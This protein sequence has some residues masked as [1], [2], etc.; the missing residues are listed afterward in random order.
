MTRLFRHS[1][2]IV[3]GR[4][5]GIFGRGRLRRGDG[6]RFLR[7]TGSSGPIGFFDLS[8][9]VSIKCEIGDMENARFE[10]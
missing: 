2:A 9:V 1:E 6:I 7:V 4:V 8:M 10:R 3:A 5:G